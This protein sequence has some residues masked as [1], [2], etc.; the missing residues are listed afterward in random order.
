MT[1]RE[2]YYNFEDR[3]IVI[4]LQDNCPDVPNSDQLDK[5]GDKIGDLCDSDMDNDGIRN[6][7]VSLR[8]IFSGGWYRRAP[9][10]K[11]LAMGY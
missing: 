2:A 8:L 9:H 7:I 11:T 10:N 1:A 6:E 3:Y 5:D 4:I